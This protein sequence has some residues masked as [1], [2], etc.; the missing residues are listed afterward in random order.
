MP[1]SQRRQSHI[2]M[3]RSPPASI[4]GSRSR[5]A[6]HGTHRCDRARAPAL[7]APR[8]RCISPS[9]GL[10]SRWST[11]AAPGEE[12][13]YGNAGV[14]EGNTLFPQPFPPFG[15]CCG[16]RSSRRRR[17]TTICRSCRRSRRGCWPTAP[18]RTPERRIEFADADAAAVR[19]RGCRARGADGRGR[20]RALSAQ[21]RLAQALPHAK[22]RSRRRARARAGATKFGL[23]HRD[24]RPDECAAR[25]SRRLRRCFATRVHWPGAASVTNPLARDPSLCGA[26]R[27]ARRRRAHRRRAHAAPRRRR[28]RVDTG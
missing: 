3:Q 5:K 9:A 22:R 28:W 18:I 2:S 27:R 7:S 10:R 1:R 25:S 15:R 6:D 4:G 12:T 24:A 19:A 16:S 23:P 21:G 26:L 8:S 11:A 13:S 20:R 14:I 17:P